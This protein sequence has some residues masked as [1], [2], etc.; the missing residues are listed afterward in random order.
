MYLT[1]KLLT[2]YGMTQLVTCCGR[3]ETESRQLSCGVR[4]T[5][6]SH[7]AGHL[8]CGKETLVKRAKKLRLNHQDYKLRD[9]LTLLRE[10]KLQTD[11]LY[12]ANT[13]SYGTH[14]HCSG[15]VSY[16]L[17]GYI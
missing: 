10:G 13:T 16:R 14:L 3:I 17:M 8:P 15:R 7:L 5:I 1:L 9:P 2:L 12:I 6:Y 11:G 4:M